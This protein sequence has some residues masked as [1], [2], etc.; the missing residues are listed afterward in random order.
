MNVLSA[1]RVVGGGRLLGQSGSAE[2]WGCGL[3]TGHTGPPEAIT[4]PQDRS[5]ALQCGVGAG[6]PHR[7]GGRGGRKVHPLEEKGLWG[8]DKL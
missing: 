5:Q 7:K 4:S 2:A 1:Q 8:E 3:Q 6:P